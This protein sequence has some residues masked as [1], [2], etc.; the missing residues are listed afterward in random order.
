MEWVGQTTARSLYPRE[1]PGTHGTGDWVGLRADLYLCGMSHPN[2]I[3]TRFKIQ[4]I[5]Q[6]ILC[7][8]AGT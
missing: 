4:F 7:C 1:R 2:K 3:C 5:E 8:A 6:H